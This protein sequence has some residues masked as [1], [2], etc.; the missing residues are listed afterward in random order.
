MLRR[1]RTTAPIEQEET[2]AAI[3]IAP[4]FCRTCGVALGNDPQQVRILEITQIED[5]WLAQGHV[6]ADD[7]CPNCGATYSILRQY[8]PIECAD[9]GCPKC[10]PS[11]S[12][13]PDVLDVKVTGE[14]YLFTATIRC[15]KCSRPRVHERV[16]GSFKKVKRLKIGPAGVEVELSN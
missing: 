7:F 16:L 9:F 14:G 6:A 8:V 12:M 2:I 4:A 5:G 3:E 13:T 1:R 10:G 11:T 15:S